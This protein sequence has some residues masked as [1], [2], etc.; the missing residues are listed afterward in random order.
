MRVL[1]TLFL[2]L[3]FSVITSGTGWAQA[4]AQLSGTVT[5][6]TGA[7]IPG[8]EVTANQ[9]DTGFSRTVVTN[10]TGSWILPNVA[11]GPYDVGATLPGF[12]TFLQTGIILQVGDS[13]VIDIVLE[14]GQV[15]QTI[16]VAATAAL[17]ETRN[18]SISQVMDTARIVDLPLNGRN[19]AQL[20]VLQGGATEAMQ[21]GGYAFPNR[22]TITSAGALGISTDYTLDGIRHIDPYDGLALPLPFPD[23]IAEFK[24][25]IGGLSA[26]QHRSAQV[27][28]VTRSGTNEF[29]GNAFW[30]VRNDLFNARHHG[31]KTH[32]TLKRNQY[33]GTVGGPALRNKLF[34]FGGYQG[35]T[36]RSDAQNEEAFVPTPAM[37]AGDFTTIVSKGCDGNGKLLGTKIENQYPLFFSRDYGSKNP[38]N[39]DGIVGNADDNHIDPALYNP[40]AKALVAKLPSTTDPCGLVTFGDFSV[41]DQYQYVTRVDYQ[42]S[43]DHTLFGRYLETQSDIPS[44]FQFSGGNILAS[45]LGTLATNY[46]FTFGVT[47]V[48]SA[49]LV[50]SFRISATRTKQRRFP[51]EIGFDA[52]DIGANVYSDAIDNAP[53]IEVEDGFELGGNIRRLGLNLFQF[54]EELSVS[55]GA[56]Q[57]NFGALYS[58][59][60][61]NT[62]SGT[63]L[64]P[65]FNFGNDMSGIGFGD[66][67]LGKPASFVQSRGNENLARM[68]FPAAWIHDMWQMS[69]TVSISAGLRWSPTF[70]FVDFRRPVPNSVM[71]DL[72][73]YK[74]GARSKV[75]TNQPPGFV[76]AG[77]AT[78]PFATNVDASKFPG[79][80]T[81]NVAAPRADLW[82]PGYNQWAPRLGFAW[83]VNGD[84]RTSVRA[85]YSLAY[86]QYPTIY[87]LGSAQAQPPWGNSSNISFPTGGMTDPWATAAQVAAGQLSNG[88][89]FPSSSSL[90][91]ELVAG[92]TYLPSE[93]DLKPTYTQS[94]NLSLQR[95]VGSDT[96][97]SATYLGTAIVHT[98][99][100]ISLN[101]TVYVPGVFDANGKCF[102]NTTIRHHDQTTTAISNHSYSGRAGSD[103]STISTRIDRR[104][105]ALTRPDARGEIGTMGMVVGGGTQNY[106]GLL[107]STTHRGQGGNS[108]NANYTWSHCIGDYL[109]RSNGG[110]GSSAQHTFQNRADRGLDRGNCTS[111]ERHALN[112]S[113][114]VQTPEFAN[115]ALNLVGSGWRLSGIYRRNS[116][117]NANRA[118][119]SAT[120]NSVQMG[121]PA[122]SQAGTRG[123]DDPAMSAIENQ[124]PL[125]VSASNMYGDTSGAAG[126]TWL[127]RSAFATPKPGDQM[128][129]PQIMGRG[130]VV[131]PVEWQFDIGMSRAFSLTENH[132]IEFRMEV[133]NVTNSYL[134]NVRLIQNYLSSK[135]FA[136]VRS[137]NAL[138]PRILQF[139]LKYDF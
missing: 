34:F 33:G 71:F 46:A 82:K 62:V 36:L 107:L 69:P 11:L 23:A 52:T 86:E 55:M 38:F 81:I 1:R 22:M 21:E 112:M 126:T 114:V 26:S 14:V 120:N 113:G 16:E 90:S 53:S 47:S 124:R 111:D 109:G 106:H 65:N 116:G 122:R 30:F 27:S 66:F 9:T 45:G 75:F 19:V 79:D 85:S 6:A 98:Q 127:N 18:V 49:N 56:H 105:L 117:G 92:G 60:R 108:L 17:V 110:Y 12:S 134:A 50:N 77:D 96:L 130:N 68:K 136:Q 64:A 133:F 95:E 128:T 20:L 138:S 131:L 5:D 7:L 102:V 41:Q 42:L 58:E 51:S 132:S 118:S 125:L 93:P 101:P 59:A 89:P 103:C 24:T 3:L 13:L 8:V 100:A 61:T 39:A 135:R 44:S 87:R 94:W 97:V 32:S 37:M 74:A 129:N 115:R 25:E 10:E 88:G 54:H 29:H 70:A 76:Y 119:D 139:A 15:A 104:E 78:Y 84:G 99:A 48:L 137:A 73:L 43:Q 2:G 31:S 40:V 35:T 83:D 121:R 57:F 28:S 4:T 80:G 63:T 67:L 72:G 91:G 123:G